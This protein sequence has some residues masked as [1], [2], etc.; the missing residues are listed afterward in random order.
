MRIPTAVLA[1]WVVL[2]RFLSID[3]DVFELQ[4]KF[5]GRQIEKDPANANAMK[6]A[7]NTENNSLS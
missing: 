5:V 1:K 6:T 3:G 7:S 4:M 2:V